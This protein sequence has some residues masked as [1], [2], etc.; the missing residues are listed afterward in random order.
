MSFY[1]KSYKN[2]DYKQLYE[3]K[4]FE[5]DG[6]VYLLGLLYSTKS[7]QSI[8]YISKR[9]SNGNILLEKGFDFGSSARYFSGIFKLS[10][11]NFVLTIFNENEVSM[12]CLSSD[13][14][15]TIWYEKFYDRKDVPLLF[16]N[17]SIFPSVCTLSND[18]IFVAVGEYH[19]GGQ[20]SGLVE[21]INHQ[22]L[23]VNGKTGTINFSKKYTQSLSFDLL[24]ISDITSDGTNVILTGKY[25]TNAFIFVIDRS[26][27]I[28]KKWF[29]NID[30]YA[31][32][33]KFLY[34]WKL[35]NVYNNKILLLGWHY[36]RNPIAQ[37]SNEPI[38]SGQ[39][40]DFEFPL[41][42]FVLNVD[43]GNFEDSLYTQIQ[44]KSSLIETEERCN[45]LLEIDLNNGI[46]KQGLLIDGNLKFLQTDYQ[47]YATD[48]NIFFSRWNELYA[49]SRSSNQNIWGKYIDHGQKSVHEYYRIITIDSVSIISSQE[50]HDRNFNDYSYNLAKTNTN[51]E[52]CKTINLD[53]HSVSL[54]TPQQGRFD[55]ELAPNKLPIY[56]PDRILN[57]VNITSSVQSDVC[58]PEDSDDSGESID[59]DENTLL[60]SPNFNLFAAGS[61]GTDSPASVQLRWILA[62]NLGEKHLPKGNLATNTNNYNKPNDF[63][64]IYKTPYQETSFSLFTF[65]FA[66]NLHSV[67][68]QKAYWIYNYQDPTSLNGTSRIF[69]VYFGNKQKYNEVLSTI[70][71]FRD[72]IGFLTAY[73]ENIIE[74]EC[75]QELFFATTPQYPRKTAYNIQLEA[76]SVEENKLVTPKIL[77][78]RDTIV[79]PSLTKI[80]CENGRSIRYKSNKLIAGFDFEFYSDFITKTNK[81][82]GWNLLG[83]FSLSTENRTVEN[84]LDPQPTTNPV[85]G[86]WLRY[87]DNAYVNTANY[88]NKWESAAPPENPLDM[89]IKHSVNQYIKLSD[90]ASNPKAE[91]EF[92]LNGIPNVEIEPEEGETTVIS[93]LDLLNIAASD[94]HVAR[95]LGLGT[96]DMDVDVLRENEFVYISVYQTIKDIQNPSVRK[97][98]KLLSMSLPTSVNTQ[99]FSLPIDIAEVKFGPTYDTPESQNLCDEDGYT[100]D[101]RYRMVKF[102]TKDVPFG[103]INPVFFSNNQPF[104][105]STF[106]LPIYAGLEYKYSKDNTLPKEWTKPELLHDRKY[107]NI[108]VFPLSYESIPIMLPQEN[109]PIYMHR[110]AE[111]GFY[112]YATYGINIFSR[113]TTSETTFDVETHLKPKNTLLPPSAVN[114]WLIMEEN[115]L[116]FTSPYEQDRYKNNTKGDKTLVRLNF[117]YDSNQDL[118][119]YSIPLDTIVPDQ[120]YINDPNNFPDEYDIFADKVEIFYRNIVPRIIMAGM[121]SAAQHPTDFLLVVFKTKNYFVASTGEMYLSDFPEGTDANNFIGG[122][123][124]L[125]NVS[126]IINGIQPGNQGLEFTVFKKEVS[127]AIISGSNY[128]D[129]QQLSFPDVTGTELFSATE[130]MQTVENWGTANPNPLKVKIGSD[131]NIHREMIYTQNEDKEEIKY[132]EKSRGIWG[133]AKISPSTDENNTVVEGVYSIRFN[134]L[135]LAE[136]TQ[137]SE[138]SNSVEWTGG[139]VRLYRKSTFVN[140]KARTSRELFKV[141]SAENIGNSDNLVLHIIDHKYDAENPQNNDEILIGN[142]VS[143]NYY[144]GYT[145]YLYADVNNNL[146]KNS[147]LPPENVLTKYSIFGIRTVDDD[148]TDTDNHPYKSK[149][150]EPAIL[151][152]QNIKEPLQPEQP[153]GALFATRPDFYGKSTYSFTVKFAQKPFSIQFYRSNDEA[154]FNALYKPETIKQIKNALNVLGGYNESFLTNRWENFFDFDVLQNAENY[155]SYPAGDENEYAFPLPD[156]VLFYQ[157]IN[158]FIDKHN[159]QYQTNNPQIPQTDFGNLPLNTIIIAGTSNNAPIKLIH[160]V[161]EMLSGTFVPLTEIPVIYQHIKSNYTPINKKQN[162]RDKYGALLPPE[163]PDF[164]MAPMISILD[165]NL[166]EV[167]FTDFTLDGTSDNVCFYGA[168]EIGT[169]MKPGKMSKVC[170]P[171]RL[172]DSN[173]PE[174]P[175]ILSG[176]P[177]LEN[178]IFGISPKIKIDIHPYPEVAGVQKIS[179]YRALNRLDAE[180]VLSMAL[181]KQMDISDIEIAEN[182][183]WTLYDELESFEQI[184]YGDTLYYRITASKRIE[185]AEPETEQI[186]IDYAPSQASKILALILTETKNPDAPQLEGFGEKSQDN[187]FVNNVKLEWNTTCYK[188]IY[189]L[190]SMTS[191]GN[192]K[193]IAR[194]ITDNTNDKVQL[195]VYEEN[196]ADHNFS[197]VNKDLLNITDGKISLALELLGTAYTQFSLFDENGNRMYYH[198]KAVAENTSGMFST[199]ENIFTLLNE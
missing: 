169:Q 65:S 95:M 181:I 110:Q 38:P 155:A 57:I 91:E 4:T 8:A 102:Y 96:L 136:H 179:L 193:E 192:W 6:F 12:L 80:F 53:T 144:P 14:E 150:C 7:N 142:N 183:V 168:R 50:N 44:N 197:W 106:T 128:I 20:A 73:G 82:S 123:F 37:K 70:N 54:F 151:F 173:P 195:Q 118:V 190:Y 1:F 125:D 49:F 11:G 42:Q 90:D 13:F 86:K 186:I 180:S 56:E 72:P 26:I 122:I 170:G 198:F 84:R 185:Y 129:Y 51:Y 132:L 115:P 149:F 114:A 101:G 154:V 126:Y 22:F 89:D 61:A 69:H 93:H 87:N 41:Q 66:E 15:K 85:H 100:F 141:I 138:N 30:N 172:V 29:F 199:Q 63:V 194:L 116:M 111:S 24:Q 108:D 62:G 191:Q 58:P 137:F 104:D 174:A 135:K 167:L 103:E 99:R 120:D 153:K 79:S 48:E 88:L 127:E 163:H 83:E 78:F 177:I 18:E 52:T 67:N 165:N 130:N 164:D 176:L 10:N 196:P 16:T 32:T 60:Q 158:L 36:S 81:N 171:V 92:D 40:N 119:T 39:E 112:Q 175:K 98:C 134:D 131:W 182:T 184:P 77:A 33:S 31:A 76:F 2:P 189:H 178:K 147:V 162:I 3:S 68:N 139:T 34:G 17:L 75:K 19:S 145:A 105:A 35:S 113:A 156:K 140:G 46:T 152:G 166:N 157:E 23:N 160:F 74:I 5:I 148:F 146:V 27:N 45:F 94:Y 59:I 188:G 21:T 64:K 71:P 43:T 55:I 107:K 161:E 109:D 9:D 121:V 28:I 143:V 133:D 25:R 159:Q 124:L 47:V 117:S 97:E 187:N